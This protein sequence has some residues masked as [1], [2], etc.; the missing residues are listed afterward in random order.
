MEDHAYQDYQHLKAK[1]MK[2]EPKPDV[3]ALTHKSKYLYPLFNRF[4]LEANRFHSLPEFARLE[5]EVL[6]FNEE[7]EAWKH[8]DREV[9]NIFLT[10]NLYQN[11]FSRI[12]VPVSS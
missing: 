6:A 3:I 7:L 2:Y 10:Y 1:K 5:A 12:K 4:E 8:H 11:L 9:K